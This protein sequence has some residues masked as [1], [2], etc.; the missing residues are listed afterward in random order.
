MERV[1]VLLGQQGEQ[2]D[3]AVVADHDLVAEAVHGHSGME[4]HPRLMRV[5]VGV[6]RVAGRNRA[7]QQAAGDP[8]SVQAAVA[9][10]QL[11]DEVRLLT[12]EIAG[13]Q[14]LT[15]EVAQPQEVRELGKPCR[16]GVSSHWVCHWATVFMP[17]A[18]PAPSRM[19]AHDPRADGQSTLWRLSVTGCAAPGGRWPA[20]TGAG[21]GTSAVSTPTADQTPTTRPSPPG[22][23]SATVCAGAWLATSCAQRRQVRAAAAGCRRHQDPDPVGLGGQRVVVGVAEAADRRRGQGRAADPEPGPGQ[24]EQPGGAQPA[25]LAQSRPAAVGGELADGHVDAEHDLD[26]LAQRRRGAAPAVQ[27]GSGGEQVAPDGRVP[28]RVEHEAEQAAQPGQHLVGHAAG[29]EQRRVALDGAVGFLE[30]GVEQGQEPLGEVRRGRILGVD[31]GQLVG[32]GDPRE[33]QPDAVHD[34]GGR[35]VPGQPQPHVQVPARGLVDEE[36]GRRRAGVLPVVRVRRAGRVAVAS[37]GPA[38]VPGGVGSSLVATATSTLVPAGTSASTRTRCQ[39]QRGWPL[40]IAVVS[41]WPV[42]CSVAVPGE[43]PVRGLGRPS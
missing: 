32:A 18:R 13:G 10:P 1:A 29:V 5:G 17:T 43:M 33:V 34:R 15:V 21:S 39:R 30:G 36:V 14:H 12:L 42:V 16:H 27:A 37:A 2:L 8:V 40:S 20:S 28:A 23:T 3:R 24:A 38:A 9:Q 26:D 41:S 6:A 11:L 31:G 35:A 4:R 7:D 19:P 22:R 25:G